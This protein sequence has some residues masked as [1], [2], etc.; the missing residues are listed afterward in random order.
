LTPRRSTS[1]STLQT[2]P[3]II[4][5]SKPFAVWPECRRYRYHHTSG[6]VGSSIRT[7]GEK[8]RQTRSTGRCRWD[9]G[10]CFDPNRDA[11]PYTRIGGGPCEMVPGLD[12]DARSQ[13]LHDG[14]ECGKELRHGLPVCSSRCIAGYGTRYKPISS[15]RRAGRS[16]V[17]THRLATQSLPLRP[18]ALRGYARHP[19][20]GF[21]VEPEVRK[22]KYLLESLV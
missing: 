1:K 12:F 20:P 14:T 16:G 4:A 9:C 10:V 18:I 3:N 5:S 8:A 2:K 15:S 21:P 17:W 7:R 19:E 13:S 22:L 6:G 11:H